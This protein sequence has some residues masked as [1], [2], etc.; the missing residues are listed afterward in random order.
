T[1][2]LQHPGVVPIYGLVQ[3]PD[4]NPSYAMRFIEG[5]SLKDVIHHFHKTDKKPR[6]PGERAVALRQL[7]NRFIAVCNTI[8][9]AHNR[10]IIH[11]DP[12]PANIML[13]K[14]GETL[15]VVWDRAR[16]SARTESQ[17]ASGEDPLMPP[18]KDGAAH[19][20]TRMG[21]TKGTPAYMSPEQA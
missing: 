20:A 7:L 10:G 19:D 18:P 17:R 2:K 11:Q 14:Y 4:G 15:V 5:E 9:F 13:G 1:G 12:K 8:A 21:S 16:S 3:G 6:D